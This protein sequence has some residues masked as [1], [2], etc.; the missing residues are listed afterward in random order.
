MFL[1][2]QNEKEYLAGQQGRVISNEC[3]TMFHKIGES[4]GKVYIYFQL[5]INVQKG[6]NLAIITS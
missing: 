4:E 2:K 3:Q 1:S 6:A 5:E